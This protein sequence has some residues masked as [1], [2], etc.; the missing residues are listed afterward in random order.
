[1]A[2][3]FQ[4]AIIMILLLLAIYL[5]NQNTQKQY[6]S[7]EVSALNIDLNL[8]ASFTITNSLDTISISKID[9]SWEIVGNDTLNIRQ[10]SIDMFFDK[11]LAVKKGTLISKNKDKW[12]IY[13]VHDTNATHLSLFDN[14]NNILGNFYIGQ[15]KSNYANSYIRINDDNNVYLTS[16]NIF[17]YMNPNVNYWGEKPPADSLLAE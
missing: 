14:Q 15:S 5:F 16:D 10:R 11:V 6:I 13:S 3:N 2:K 12:S 8:I 4:I 9:T 1:M 7:K 17:Y